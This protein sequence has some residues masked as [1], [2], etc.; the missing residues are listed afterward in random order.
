MSA[1]LIVYGTFGAWGLPTV[2]PFV[3]KLET[4]LRIAGIPYEIRPGNPL[5]A[6]KGKVPY[7]ELDG[8]LMGD[9]EL[10]IAELSR[11]HPLTH[12]AWLTPAQAA[13][14]HALRRMLE[15]GTYFH[16]VRFRWI[17][18][19]GWPHQVAAFSPHMPPLIGGL[20]LGSICRKL[21]K[22][23]LLQGSGRHDRAAA[24][25]SVAADYAANAGHH[26]RSVPL[27]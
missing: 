2:S 19:D 4:W 1:P 5:R 7:V 25:V 22:T 27:W 26:R 23:A 15:E 14:G 17:E 3:M 21:R 11:R 12:D 20:I 8:Q 16:T 10:I 6:P 9:S 24:A 18:D 13:V